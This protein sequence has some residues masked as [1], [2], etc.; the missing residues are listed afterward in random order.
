MRSGH[1]TKP[2]GW[3]YEW[4]LTRYISFM[5]KVYDLQLPSLSLWQLVLV[6][7]I[8]RALVLVVL[9]SHIDIFSTTN[10]KKH[11]AMVEGK[12][13]NLDVELQRTTKDGC[14]L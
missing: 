4:F 9:K 13:K 8:L 6:Y 12:P 11:A 2:F 3:W 7:Q 1:L 10:T 5:L 14:A